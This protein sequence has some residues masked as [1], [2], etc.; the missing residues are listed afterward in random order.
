MVVIICML[1]HLE[2][3]GQPAKYPRM[4]GTCGSTCSLACCLS[5][6]LHM[7]TLQPSGC[8]TTDQP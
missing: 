5:P 6:N 3:V 1:C 4:V 2:H 8:M 7:V